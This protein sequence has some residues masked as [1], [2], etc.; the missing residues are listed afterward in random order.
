[1]F[2]NVDNLI[3]NNY[4]KVE[5]FTLEDCRHLS[6]ASENN[7]DSLLHELLL[8][9]TKGSNIAPDKFNSLL[10]ARSK[11]INESLILNNGQN[12][13][14]LNL[15]IFQ[16]SLREKML[17][18][19]ER[20]SIDGLDIIMDYPSKLYFDNRE[21]LII[22]CIKN[23]FISDKFINLSDLDN[24]QKY[25]ILNKLKGST[26]DYLNSFIIKNDKD[27]ILMESKFDLEP[28]S[29]NFFNNSAFFLLKTLYSYYEYDSII[30]MIFI[31]SKR[32]NDITFLNSRTPM[33]LDNLIRLYEN[34][35][36]TKK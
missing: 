34:E 12:N 14:T 1:M 8:A 27:I 7:S 30:E 25:D 28:I 33:E 6:F 3:S 5:S 22:D 26:I 18:V 29:V 11:F 9:K 15:N 19:K 24:S 31:L 32:F 2:I 10:T 36:S 16:N 4:S 13:V 23:I 21:D 35:N 17:P 20:L